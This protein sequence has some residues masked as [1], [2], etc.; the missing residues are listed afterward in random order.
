MRRIKKRIITKIRGA[1]QGTRERKKEQHFRYSRREK[2]QGGN[3]RKCEFGKRT[4]KRRNRIGRG[5]KTEKK[6]GARKVKRLR[7]EADES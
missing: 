6:E 7:V 1:R 3:V 5:Q 2:M 4:K